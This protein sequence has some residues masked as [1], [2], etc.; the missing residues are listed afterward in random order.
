[1]FDGRT[2]LVLSQH[3]ARFTPHSD[4]SPL[5]FALQCVLREDAPL[6]SLG[7]VHALEPVVVADDFGWAMVHTHEDH[8]IGGPYFVRAESVGPDEPPGSG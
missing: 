2:P 1:M 8:K 7:G 6:P 3:D 5:R 4:A